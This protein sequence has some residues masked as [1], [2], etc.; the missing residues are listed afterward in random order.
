MGDDEY[1]IIVLKNVA[2][3]DGGW[4]ERKTEA[5]VTTCTYVDRCVSD[6]Q[7]I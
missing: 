4:T 1:E 2:L 3:T 7:P 5:S 6:T